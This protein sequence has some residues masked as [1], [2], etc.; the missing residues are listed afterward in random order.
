MAFGTT[1][2]LVENKAVGM[3]QIAVAQAPARLTSVLGS[4]VGVAMYHPRMHLGC[5]A[6]VV[7]PRASGSVAA[8]G[9]FADSAVPHML[10]LLEKQGANRGGLVVKICGGACMFNT[11][12][13]L[14]IGDANIEAVTAVL[15]AAGLHIAARDVGG[16]AGRRVA[17]DCSTGQLTVDTAG[18]HSRI[19]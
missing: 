8:P 2:E 3:G 17:L 7:L 13:P 1:T 10:Q 19:L 9:K 4:C 16:T 18:S 12:G 14:Q 6:H 5:L 11:T 15:Q